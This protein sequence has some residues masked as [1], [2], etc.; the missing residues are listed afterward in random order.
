MTFT[1]AVIGILATCA[2][3]W[4]LGGVMAQRVRKEGSEEPMPPLSEKL[5]KGEVLPSSQAVKSGYLQAQM[6][7]GVGQAKRSLEDTDRVNLV[8]PAEWVEPPKPAKG[9]FGDDFFE[10]YF[11]YSTITRAPFDKLP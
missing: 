2:L 5:R 11:I 9:D 7:G 1:V 3:G 6:T 10:L 8:E 4:M